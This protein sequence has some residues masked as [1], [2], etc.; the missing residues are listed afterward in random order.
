MKFSGNYDNDNGYLHFGVVPD[1]R[2]ALTFDLPKTMGQG[3]S[4]KRLISQ[5]S[6]CLCAAV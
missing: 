4:G 3:F 1:S 2:G 5:D 6:L